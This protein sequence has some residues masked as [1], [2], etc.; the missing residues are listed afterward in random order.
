MAVRHENGSVTLTEQEFKCC[1]AF[2]EL[3][4]DRFYA[5]LTEN[6]DGFTKEQLVQRIKQFIQL[7][8]CPADVRAN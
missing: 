6:D 2:M 5:F 3:S 7:A 8:N 4:A 1:A